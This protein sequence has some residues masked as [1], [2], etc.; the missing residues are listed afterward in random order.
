MR[1]LLMPPMYWPPITV[2]A[3]WWRADVVVFLDTLRYQKQ[4]Y[5]NRARIRTPQGWQWL[6]A[7]VRSGRSAQPRA[8]ADIELD[9]SHR[10]FDKHKKAFEFFYRRAMY[11][12]YYED[13]FMP[14]YEGSAP[15]R[16]R[17]LLE[18]TLGWLW[19]ALGV[20]AKSLW[21][22]AHPDWETRADSGTWWTVPEAGL[23]PRYRSR[24]GLLEAEPPVYEQAF[25]GFEPNLSVLDLLFNLGPQAAERLSQAPVR[26]A[27]V[28]R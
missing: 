18:P 2:A 17:E 13:R 12:E 20:P 6:I 28:A 7:P 27:D 9:T 24:C 19:E 1:W 16:L 26:R 11:F 3:S 5:Q 22:S 21:A 25:S 15:N 8:I 14:L 23:P 10:W 4:S